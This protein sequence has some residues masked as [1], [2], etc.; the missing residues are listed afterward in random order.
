MKFKLMSLCCLVMT[1]SVCAM[2]N[3]RNDDAT[4]VK[5][6]YN[7][8]SHLLG[9]YNRNDNNFVIVVDQQ[10]V[11]VWDL[12]AGTRAIELKNYIGSTSVFAFSQDGNRLV[13]MPYGNNVCIWDVHTGACTKQFAC[14]TAG[15][16]IAIALSKNGDRLVT[17]SDHNE[18]CLWNVATEECLKRLM[19]PAGRIV[20]LTFNGDGNH[21]VAVTSDGALYN[22]AKGCLN[23]LRDHSCCV[24]ATIFDGDGSH[25]VPLPSMHTVRIYDAATGAC[26]KEL[27]GNAGCVVAAAFNKENDRLVAVSSDKSDKKVC[28]WNIASGGCIKE[29]QGQIDFVKTVTF[30]KTGCRVATVA[31]NGAVRIWQD[32]QLL[33][34]ITTMATGLHARCGQHSVLR[35]LPSFVIQYIAQIVQQTQSFDGAARNRNNDRCTIS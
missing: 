21:F 9:R 11:C 22:D 14:P 19:F 31:D 17:S 15:H 32:D 28:L 18:V 4:D 12:F 13:T 6:F 27:D 26:T 23:K 2:R 5:T 34:R 30:D 7:L 10:K 25:L 35:Q 1:L 29:L 3:G 33:R 16:I 8:P 24:L 20:A